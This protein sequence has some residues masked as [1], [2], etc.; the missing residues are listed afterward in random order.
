LKAESGLAVLV[1][2]S[3][4]VYP[5]LA[6][7]AAIYG[8]VTVE[9]TV[10]QNGSV[11]VIAVT[12]HPMLKSAALD[13]ARKSQWECRDCSKPSKYALT[14]AFK[15][16]QENDCCS[17]SHETVVEQCSEGMDKQGQVEAQIIVSTRFQ[18]I[19]DPAADVVNRRS[20]K[21]LYLWKCSP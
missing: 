5:P 11:D 20:I 14:Y 3:K 10:E 1:S 21:C 15:L 2:L 9:V 12:G 8:D 19:C 13:S 4:P 7:M 16:I 6:R 17:A 18:C